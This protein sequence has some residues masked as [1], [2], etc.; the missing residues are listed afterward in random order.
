MWSFIPIF[1]IYI[2]RDFIESLG[3]TIPKLNGSR[4]EN[5]KSESK[6]DDST[7]P[8]DNKEEEE[9]EEEDSAESE[10][11]FDMDGV[12]GKITALL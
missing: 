12:I 3:G 9:E 7:T 6:M 5:F 1:E 2:Y 8:E 11:D 4:E 10:I